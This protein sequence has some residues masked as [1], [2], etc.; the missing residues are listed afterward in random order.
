MVLLMLLHAGSGGA[1]KYFLL[2]LHVVLFVAG[3]RWILSA[4]Q[5][6][7]C[8]DATKIGDESCRLMTFDV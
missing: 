3:G 4:E 1:A 2:S 6:V 7:L 8:A 5:L